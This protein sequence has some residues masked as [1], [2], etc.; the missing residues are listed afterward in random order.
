MLSDHHEI[1][2]KIDPERYSKKMEKHIITEIEL[3]DEVI[4]KLALQAHEQDITLNQHINNVL[5]VK[6]EKVQQENPQLLNE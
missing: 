6:L 4:L 3:E 1:R 5:R 2:E